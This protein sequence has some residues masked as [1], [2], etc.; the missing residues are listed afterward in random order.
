MTRGIGVLSGSS[1]VI[2]Q[3][4]DDASFI[5]G[6][7]LP[8]IIQMSGSLN[9]RING[10]LSSNRWLRLTG[11]DGNAIWSTMSASIIQNTPLG[12]LT[13]S[14][15][16][17]AINE[18]QNHINAVSL[19]GGSGSYNFSDGLNSS[20]I[21]ANGSTLIITGTTS[22]TLSTYAAGKYIIGMAPN[23]LLTGSTLTFG[24][25]TASNGIIVQAGGL[26]IQNGGTNVT[27]LTASNGV[28]ISSGSLFVTAGGFN[29][30]GGNSVL[31][32]VVAG[33]LTS[34]NGI[35]VS[36]GGLTVTLGNTTLQATTVGPL[37]AS[38]GI[39]VTGLSSLQTV[40][41]T[42]ISSSANV[43]AQNLVITGSTTLGTSGSQ[44]NSTIFNGL[45]QVPVFV[46]GNVP[47]VYVNDPFKYV[48]YMF[49]LQGAGSG[50]FSQSNKWYHNENG[51]WFPSMFFSGS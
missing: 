48:G 41:A 1:T 34:S 51:T 20:V 30:L 29:V 12:N 3:A 42:T 7:D 49:Y 24:P 44:T 28:S 36:T 25:L 37:T 11:S 47:S 21:F 17:D 15:V 4:T 19:A 35:T 18:L 40:I 13:S 31:Q 2:F 43:Y 38:N 26:A 9:L 23:I 33:P 10:A 22:Q 8:A 46:A 39:T 5:V 32:S 27:S 16:Q 50:T 45:F 14:I 6:R